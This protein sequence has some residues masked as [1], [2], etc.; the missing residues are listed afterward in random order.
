MVR[1]TKEKYLDEN[2]KFKF[3]TVIIYSK[4]EHEELKKFISD[5]NIREKI[6]Y[7]LILDNTYVWYLSKDLVERCIKNFNQ[8]N[9][10]EL[11]KAIPNFMWYYSTTQF[12]KKKTE[13]E[14]ENNSFVFK[15]KEWVQTKEL[16]EI[17]EDIKHKINIS[18]IDYI[19]YT[20][21]SWNYWIQKEKIMPKWFSIIIIF[22]AKILWKATIL[23]EIVKD[24]WKQKQMKSMQERLDNRIWA[25]EFNEELV[26]WKNIL[27]IDD[28]ITTWA[29]ML[30]IIQDIQKKWW[31]C[32]CYAVAWAE[33]DK[34]FK[35]E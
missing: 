35:K 10:D 4:Q 7:K 28:V 1:F 17:I 30:A 31:N 22:I 13:R 8:K 21:D 19:T 14:I 12:D 24:M 26:K 16:Q 5:N 20:P 33:Q 27:F 18:K 6:E 2:W 29:T 11:K 32:Y 25:Y 34:D 15:L 3:K 9:I 23:P